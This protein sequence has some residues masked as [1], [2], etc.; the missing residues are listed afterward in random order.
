MAKLDAPILPPFLYRYRR[1]PSEREEMLDPNEAERVFKRELD[2]IKHR[3]LHFSNYKAMNDAMEGFYD[4][5]RRAAKDPNFSMV[6]NNIYHAKL[7][8]GLCCFSDTHNK[9]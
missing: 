2:A 9:S 5:S 8:F 1:L 4:P 3:Q 7:D 6:A